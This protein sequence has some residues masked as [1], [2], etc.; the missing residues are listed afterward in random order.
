M[1]L[2][3]F[4]PLRGSRVGSFAPLAQALW[5]PIRYNEWLSSIKPSCQPKLYLSPIYDTVAS[6]PTSPGR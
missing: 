5:P 3:F 4:C 6:S 2:R 1:L